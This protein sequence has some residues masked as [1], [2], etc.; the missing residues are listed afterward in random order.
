MLSF[1]FPYR[2]SVHAS[3]SRL[4]LSLSTRV[5]YFPLSLSAVLQCVRDELALSNKYR[6]CIWWEISTFIHIYC[7]YTYSLF[8]FLL[9]LFWYF[10]PTFSVS[11]EKAYLLL[12]TLQILS[13]FIPL[14]PFLI[15]LSV[16]CYFVCLTSV[17]CY[18]LLRVVRRFYWLDVWLY[19]SIFI[20]ISRFSKTYVMI[21]IYWLYVNS[22]FLSLSSHFTHLSYHFFLLLS[23]VS[24][25]DRLAADSTVHFW[26]SVKSSAVVS[27]TGDSDSALSWNFLPSLGIEA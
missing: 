15:A 13:L 9:P 14:F 3:R 4:S 6:T 25:K 20:N 17:Y 23:V 21:Q 26:I 19:N 10:W 27:W 5:H 1:H 18:F 12:Q 11:Q 22:H 16:F 2:A 8:S 24:V 7:N